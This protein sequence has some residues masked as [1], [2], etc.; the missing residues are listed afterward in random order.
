MSYEV[1]RRR[2]NALIQKTG[3][4]IVA[5][6]SHNQDTGRHTAVCSDGTIITGNDISLKVTVKWGSGHTAVAAI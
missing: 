6:F 3:G 4:G 1:F 2:I 5:V